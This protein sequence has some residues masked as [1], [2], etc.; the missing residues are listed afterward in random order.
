M[1]L[2][3][4][5]CYT[6]TPH[7]NVTRTLAVLFSPITSQ[8]TIPLAATQNSPGPDYLRNSQTL[9][10]IYCVYRIEWSNQIHCV[11]RIEWAVRIHCTYRIE[12]AVQIHC[13]YRIE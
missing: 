2:Y 8:T 7:C 12:W 13:A 3:G 10:N 9:S 1:L 6:N 11:Y 4:C 5:K